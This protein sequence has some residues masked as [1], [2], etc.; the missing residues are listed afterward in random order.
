MTP[1]MRNLTVLLIVQLLLALWLFSSSNNDIVS[2]PLLP[3]LTQADSLVLSSK[4][5]ELTLTKQGDNWQLAN[6][7]P[8]S[9]GKLDSLLRDLT[10]LK[11]GW[12][13]AQSSEA[14]GRFS[15]ADDK[16]EQKLVLMQGEKVLHTLY[17]GDS[18]AF[19]QL[20]VRT[21][22]D[23]AIY[24]AALNRFELSAEESAWLDKQLLR[25]PVVERI[26]QGA[27]SLSRQGD[28]WQLS[29]NGE[30]HTAD[31]A[32]A[33][34]LVAKLSSLSVLKRAEKAPLSSDITEL[35]V[36]SSARDY[37]YQLVKQDDTALIRRNDIEHWFELSQSQFDQLQAIDWLALQRSDEAQ[38]DKLSEVAASEQSDQPPSSD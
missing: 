14:Q 7:L 3:K 36:R 5:G 24:K 15:V 11:S 22:G 10:A 8:V 30:S 26:A 32:A 31:S 9:Q 16:F 29:L 18:P 35:N 21:D 1:L 13:V 6:G 37:Q 4:D 17:L 20:Y 23:E 2:E 25:L 19:R 38:G 34:D 12:P 27:N 28:N 33:R